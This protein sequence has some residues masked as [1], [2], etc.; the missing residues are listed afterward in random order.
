MCRSGLA[1]PVLD[2]RSRAAKSFEDALA[3]IRA[4]GWVGQRGSV[5]PHYASAF[6][7]EA[8]FMGGSHTPDPCPL[9]T[10]VGLRMDRAGPVTHSFVLNCSMCIHSLQELLSVGTF[11]HI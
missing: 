1:A 7:R 4:T 3:M 9:A 11:N 6:G 8:V 5:S 10:L 2:G